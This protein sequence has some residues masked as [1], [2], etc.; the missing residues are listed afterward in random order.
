MIEPKHVL[1]LM[2]GV[3]MMAL[4]D[5]EIEF[6]MMDRSGR[7]PSC[8]VCLY[9]KVLS[10]FWSVKHAEWTGRQK[11]SR[12]VRQGHRFK[13]PFGKDHYDVSYRPITA[14]SFV[15]WG[16][17]RGASEKTSEGTLQ[18]HA[19][20]DEHDLPR[21][22]AFS[23]LCSD[24]WGS[25]AFSDPGESPENHADGWGAPRR[26]SSSFV[27]PGAGVPVDSM[28]LLRTMAN[29]R[30]LEHDSRKLFMGQGDGREGV[31]LGCH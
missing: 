7:L 19:A 20:Q 11:I 26:K 24:C 23:S 18:R 1:N 9:R 3:T 29:L 21:A 28:R 22:L 16:E 13:A 25:Y 10:N 4:I 30:F 27:V 5:D 6:R 31:S 12:P 15:R 17:G 14:L 2:A 8:V